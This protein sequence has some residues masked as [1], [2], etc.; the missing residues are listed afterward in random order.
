MSE[1]TALTD[2]ELAQLY[3]RYGLLLLRRCKLILRDAELAHD[4]VQEAFVKIMRSEVTLGEIAHPLRWLYRIT[5]RTCLDLIRKRKHRPLT[6]DGEIPEL[7]TAHP[8]VGHEE[9]NLVLRILETLDDESQTIALLA[10]V[11]GMSQQEIGD[12]RG[13]SRVTINKKLASIRAAA[14]HYLE[15]SSP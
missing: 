12:E 1:E 8:D 9:R 5:D 3:T 14:A 10:F 4:A 2:V 11:D 7:P 15:R 6:A 13:F